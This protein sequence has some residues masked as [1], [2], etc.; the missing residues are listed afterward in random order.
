M[1][2]TLISPIVESSDRILSLLRERIINHFDI[3]EVAS[4]LG[5][6]PSTLRKILAGRP[7]SR[8]IK[9]KIGPIL[10]GKEERG[11]ID[12]KRYGIERLR[13]AYHLYQ[14]KK[15]LQGVGDEMGLSRE[16]VRQ[17]LVNG[18]AVGLFEYKPLYYR[19]DISREKL[20]DD[21][22]RLLTLKAVA[23][24]NKTSISCLY[25]LFKLHYITD[26]DLE[27]RKIARWKRLC[28]ERYDTAVRRLGRHPTT[29]ELQQMGLASSLLR[30]IR[31]LWG[32]IHAFRRECGIS[33]FFLS[34]RVDR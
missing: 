10:E 7:I 15:T 2:V 12:R 8:F 33:G 1:S 30:N 17:L 19:V 31:K 25:R 14:Q 22:E 27:E 11:S 26:H 20:L 29:T 4:N 24:A 6:T 34:K 13:E 9:K 3:L 23:Q 28:I 5:V 16:R 21:Y 32:S 18:A